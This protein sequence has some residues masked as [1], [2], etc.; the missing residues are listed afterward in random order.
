MVFPAFPRLISRGLIE[1]LKQVRAPAGMDI[2]ASS[3][4][5]GFLQGLA[6]WKH[7]GVIADGGIRRDASLHLAAL[8]LLFVDGDEQK[9]LVLRRYILGLALTAFTYLPTGY[10][11]QGC[12][13]VLDL[14]PGKPRE[15][16]EVYGDG[17]RIP[18]TVNQ[19]EAVGY[20]QAA[21]SGFGIGGDRKVKFDENEAKVDIGKA[22]GK[23]KGKSK[24]KTEGEHKKGA[25]SENS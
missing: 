11:R 24:D 3:P 19:D 4:Q 17:R 22:S 5:R 13:L 15:F 10:L 2:G 21:A 16:F 14:D 1:R 20:A 7:G 18:A 6:S 8:R 23:G 12:N 9:T 25:K